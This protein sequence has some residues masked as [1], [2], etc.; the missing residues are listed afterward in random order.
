MY[1]ATLKPPA[2]AFGEAGLWIAND[3]GACPIYET[4]LARHRAHRFPSE[5]AAWAAIAHVRES[6]AYGNACVEEA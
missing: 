1:I 6:Y 3:P 4:T 5:R 2:P